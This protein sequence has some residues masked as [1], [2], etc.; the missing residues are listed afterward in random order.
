MSEVLEHNTLERWQHDPLTFIAEVLRNPKTGK[1][2]EL[3]E[4]QIV[5][6]QARVDAA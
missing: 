3:F 6:L 4:A 1:A 2:F 5:V